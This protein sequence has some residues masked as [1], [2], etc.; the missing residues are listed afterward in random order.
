MSAGW[1]LPDLIAQS[2]LYFCGL[3]LSNVAFSMKK[4]LRW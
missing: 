1:S 2:K 3:N 4:R